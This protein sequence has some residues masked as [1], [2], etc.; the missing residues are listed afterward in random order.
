MSPRGCGSPGRAALTGAAVV[1]VAVAVGCDVL[2]GERPHHTVG[3]AVVAL[4]VGVLRRWAAGRDRGA[5]TAVSGAL[6]AQPALHLTT[7]TFGTAGSTAVG[8]L[9]VT[10]LHVVLAGTVVLAVTSAAYLFHLLGVRA[11]AQVRRLL[12]PPER[13][14]PWPTPMAPAAAAPVVVDDHFLVGLRRRGP[15]RR[16]A[17]AGP[18]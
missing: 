12:F 2:T 3:L 10:V 15:P 5:L 11:R 1:T 16:S 17:V 18:T 14:H 6:V 13:V 9:L 7:E 4:V 8:D